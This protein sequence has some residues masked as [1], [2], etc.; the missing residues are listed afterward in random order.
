[1]KDCIICVFQQATNG[2]TTTQAMENIAKPIRRF[3]MGG[4][5][6]RAFW[7]VV[8]CKKGVHTGATLLMPLYQIFMNDWVTNLKTNEYGIVVGKNNAI[9]PAYVDDL[10]L[11]VLYKQRLNKLLQIEYDHSVD[12]F[13][14]RKVLFWGKDTTPH[15]SVTVGNGKLTVVSKGNIG[16]AVLNSEKKIITVSLFRQNSSWFKSNRMWL[17]TAKISIS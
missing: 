9:C 2:R 4:F 13:A 17:Y 14:S 12:I 7:S 8:Q 5:D 1:M 3:L 10:A 11:L 6:R 15:M 16:D